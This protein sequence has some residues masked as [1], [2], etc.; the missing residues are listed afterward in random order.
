MTLIAA[1]PNTAYE[2]MLLCRLSATDVLFLQQMT[3]VCD[4]C[5]QLL[6]LKIALFPVETAAQRILAIFDR[7]ANTFFDI[8][9]VRPRFRQRA[10]LRWG[11]ANKL[12]R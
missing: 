10:C 12:R 9:R 5:R 1:P 3:S 8:G 11:A 6:Q 2:T 4:D 7:Q